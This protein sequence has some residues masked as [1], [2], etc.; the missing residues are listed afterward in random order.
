[1]VVKGQVTRFQAAY[2]SQQEMEAVIGTL[3]VEGGRARRRPA[4]DQAATGTDGRA[5]IVGGNGASP[6]RSLVGAVARQLR[7]I[8]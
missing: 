4:E 2:V 8:K 6:R 1:V 7:L 3:R 5:S